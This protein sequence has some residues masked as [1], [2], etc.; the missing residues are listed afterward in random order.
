[1]LSKYASSHWHPQLYIENAI[2]DLKE[3]IGYSAK[4]SEEDN[5]VY[6]NERREI[7]GLFWEKL[8]LQHFP[9]DIQ[10]LSI[11]VTSMLYD[12]KVL[13]ILDPDNISGVNR[14][15]FID[16]QEWYLYK[17]VDSEERSVAEFIL[18]S[19]ED[20]DE[21]DIGSTVEDRKRP[22]LTVTCHAGLYLQL[23]KILS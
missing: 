4:R 15:V 16:Q 2:G 12:D 8:E 18:R 6:V 20:E 13:L 22:V 9:S 17:H 1:M 3:Q 14:E 10:D 7:K 5:Q 11:S 21:R 19:D 23:K